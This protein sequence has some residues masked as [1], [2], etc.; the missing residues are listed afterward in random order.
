MRTVVVR[1]PDYWKPGK[2]YL[3]EIE[4][5]G[6]PDEVSRVNALLSGDVHIVGW[7]STR[8]RR[9]GI[10]AS[11]GH[12]HAGDAKS[13][14]LHRPDHA[15]GHGCPRGNPDFV[16]AMKYLLDRALIKRALFRGYATIAN[17]QPIPPIHPY[18]N[19]GLPQRAYDP[20]KARWHS[21]SAPGCSASA[22]RSY[23]SPAAEGSVDMAS[24]LQETA[25]SAS[26]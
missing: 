23:A 26:A 25:R 4:L 7:R 8:A 1:N 17:D 24:I 22:C 16:L 11:A 15:P 5:I 10:G 18:Y 6:I 12:S 20:E 14:A 2:P 19:A 21:R 13:G 9:A 3:D